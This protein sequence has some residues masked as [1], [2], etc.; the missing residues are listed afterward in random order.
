[1]LAATRQMRA[2]HDLLVHG[3]DAERDGLVRRGERAGWPSQMT[4][5][6]VAA[7]TPVRSLMSVDLPAPFS[8]TM[9][10]ISPGSKARSTGFSACVPA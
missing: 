1:M 4:S 5:P 9:A 10:W 6:A 2:E 7:M 3:V 8:P